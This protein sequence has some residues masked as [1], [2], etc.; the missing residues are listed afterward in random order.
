[1]ATTRKIVIE[2]G[3]VVAASAALALSG[4]VGNV[5]GLTGLDTAHAQP[6]EVD[7]LGLSVG[8]HSPPTDCDDDA[9]DGPGR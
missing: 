9:D 8:E 7:D 2:T 5:I 3:L 1:M 4:G 6:C